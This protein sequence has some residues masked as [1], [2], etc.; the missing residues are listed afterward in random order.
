MANT[1]L[2]IPDVI[3]KAAARIASFFP[4]LTPPKEEP[5]PTFAP[6]RW[7]D[8]A[9]LSSDELVMIGEAGEKYRNAVY[10]VLGKMERKLKRKGLPRWAEDVLKSECSQLGHVYELACRMSFQYESAVCAANSKLFLVEH[11][12]K[13]SGEDAETA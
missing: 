9:G 4:W 6:P 5:K 10:G 8:F 7:A 11:I 1:A 13:Q 12:L 2:S 3:G